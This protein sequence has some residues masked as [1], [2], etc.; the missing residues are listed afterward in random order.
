[1]NAIL[2]QP[3]VVELSDWRAD[4][5]VTMA[6]FHLLDSRVKGLL[7]NV[8]GPSSFPEK[9]AFIFFLNW[10][11]VQTEVINC[12]I[13]GDFNLIA[14]LGENKGGRR[15][16]DK[17]QE[18]FYEFPSQSPLVDLEMGNRWYTCNNK[19]GGEPLVASLLENSWFHRILFMVR[20]RYWWMFSL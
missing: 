18:A 7:G 5:F 17:Y 1:M 2:W 10:I 13:G 20:G 16:L 6:C 9:Q 3:R 8:Y 4:K 15:I 14:N 11:K 12:V 19:R